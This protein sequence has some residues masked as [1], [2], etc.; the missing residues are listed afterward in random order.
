MDI[1][2]ADVRDD[3][4]ISFGLDVTP[5]HNKRCTS[6]DNTDTAWRSTRNMGS[7]SLSRDNKHTRSPSDN[8]I[9]QADVD[10]ID[11]ALVLD[12]RDEDLES[13]SR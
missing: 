12:F 7:R 6:R 5:G 10:G 9:V 11:V 1:Q 8:G 4:I 3:S 2:H 13:V